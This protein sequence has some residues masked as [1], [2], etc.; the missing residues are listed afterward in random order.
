MSPLEMIAEGQRLIADGLAALDAEL[1]VNR[2]RVGC[3]ALDKGPDVGHHASMPE[4][5]DVD[6]AARVMGVTSVALRKRIERGVIG[7]AHGLIDRPGRRLA[8]HRPTL[9]AKLA[10]ETQR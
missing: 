3:P 10:A 4:L 7:R 1:R 6:G 9:L 2:P 5:L 8:F